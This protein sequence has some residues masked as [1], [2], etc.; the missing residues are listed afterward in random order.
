MTHHGPLPASSGGRLRDAQ[1]IPELARLANLEVWAVSRNAT[2]DRNALIETPLCSQFRVFHDESTPRHYPTRDSAAVRAL[3]AA[4]HE[5]FDVIHIEGHY[6][7]HLLPRAAHLRSVVVEHNVESHLLSQAIKNK[8]SLPVSENDIYAVRRMEHAAW[9]GAGLILTLSTEDR[10]RIVK[11]LPLKNVRV[12]ANGSDHIVQPAQ[13]E[14]AENDRMTP[15][16]GF[17]ANYAY[18]PN[19]DAL[20]WLVRKIFPPIQEE[21]PGARLLLAGSNLKSAAADLEMPDGVEIV[22]WVESASEF[23]SNID[24]A[25]CP[26]RIGGGVKVKMLEMAH[27][28]T[29]TVATSVSTEGLPHEIRDSIWIADAAVEFAAAATRLGKDDNLRTIFREKMKS[30]QSEL[31]TWSDAARDLYSHWMELSQSSPPPVDHG[32]PN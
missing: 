3:L 19:I 30:A 16:F 27:C 22:G 28:A 18:P 1:L 10:D 24:V 25:L 8:S 6:L 4:E 31:P 32:G 26:L 2:A 9:A 5:R 17:L 7:F 20:S 29:P 13:H 11:R 14:P 12:A 15:H 23:L 21:I